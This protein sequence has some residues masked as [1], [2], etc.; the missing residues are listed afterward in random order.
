M[1]EKNI[2]KLSNTQRNIWLVDQRFSNTNVNNIVGELKFNT[3]IDIETLKRAV[4]L[5]VKK[6]DA[7]RIK[8][9]YH[10][11]ILEQYIDVRNFQKSIKVRD[12]TICFPIHL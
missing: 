12:N 5:L 11:G 10:D 6:N 2:Y 8:M 1:E 7:L 4:N 9:E 3:K